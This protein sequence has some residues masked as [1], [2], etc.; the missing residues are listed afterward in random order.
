MPQNLLS[1]C[2]HSIP[3]SAELLNSRNAYFTSKTGGKQTLT[4]YIVVHSC[5]LLVYEFLSYMFTGFF[6]YRF[7]NSVVKQF[8]LFACARDFGVFFCSPLLGDKCA[9]NARRQFYFIRWFIKVLVNFLEPG[10]ALIVDNLFLQLISRNLLPL[11][12]RP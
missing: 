11:E 12:S 5:I 4:N 2:L 1:I 10:I 6:C 8:M 3:L 7:R 9:R